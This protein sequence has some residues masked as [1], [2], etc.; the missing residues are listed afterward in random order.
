MDTKTNDRV[1]HRSSLAWHWPAFFLL[2]GAGWIALFVVNRSTTTHVSSNWTSTVAMWLA[3]SIVMMS[4]T[5]IPV[6]QALGDVVR[7]SSLTVWWVFLVAYLTMWAL[8]SI[9]AA[10]LQLLFGGFGWMDGH[11]TQSW[12][13]GVILLSAGAYQFS[14]LKQRCQSECVSPMTFFLRYWREG[15]WGGFKMG[16]RH[17]ATCIGCCWALMLLAFVGGMV[18][19]AFMALCALVMTLE[20]FPTIGA[21]IT[22]PLGIALVAAGISVLAFDFINAVPTEVH[23]HL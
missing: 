20:K 15:V 12:L 22:R 8:F 11:S 13:S 21:K 10:S 6:L 5:A 23:Q 1:A 18:N 7:K 2:I 3:M 4:T 19:A 16:L 14:S 17:G 9:V